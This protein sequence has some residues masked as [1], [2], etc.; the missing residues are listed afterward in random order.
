[1]IVVVQLNIFKK[2]HIARVVCIRG[3]GL[4]IFCCDRMHV[5]STGLV[6]TEV[7]VCVVPCVSWLQ[8]HLS[9]LRVWLGR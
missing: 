1:M 5:Y 8:C 6:W 9:G 7:G 4:H 3:T 2:V